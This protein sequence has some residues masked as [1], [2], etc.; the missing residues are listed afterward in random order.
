MA[1]RVP[2]S[3]PDDWDDDTAA[4]LEKVARHNDG[5]VLNVLSTVA[6]HPVLLQKWMPFGNHI[7]GTNTLP[8]REREL[9]TLR[10]GLLAGSVYEWVQHVSIARAVGCTDEEI[11]R[12]VA[13]PDA[14]GWGPADRALLRATDELMAGGPAS[15][16]LR[17]ISRARLLTDDREHRHVVH[18]RVIQAIK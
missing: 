12:V 4:L 14:P 9:A 18:L 2:L 16:Y 1:P 3:G 15:L 5:K 8:K 17:E 10:V 6:R 7:L 11:E 13:G